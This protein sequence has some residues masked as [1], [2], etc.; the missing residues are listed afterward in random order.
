MEKPLIIAIPERAA[1]AL[2]NFFRLEAAGGILLIGAALLALILANSPFDA[3]Y[4]AV[5][6][7]TVEVRVGL[8]QIDKPL[9]LWINDG[10]MAVF[11]LMVA[12]EM[13]REALYGQLSSRDQLVLPLACAAG[14][15]AVPSAIYAA[16]NHHDAVAM[17][18]WAIPA[19]TD[20]A[21]ALG[22]LSLLGSRAPLSLKVLL[23][24]IAV[25]DDLA[26][27]IIIAIFYTSSLSTLALGGAAAALAGMILLNRL[28][29]TR[30]SAYILLRFNGKSFERIY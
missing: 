24:A 17:S 16:F 13:K 20:I 25:I 2:R 9:L 27:I 23:S 10:L 22:I 12:L 15:V 4:R 28:G 30:I 21:F 29:V 3:T 26:A 18:G 19:A 5:L 6:D 1:I 8:N 7:V 11:F 14:G